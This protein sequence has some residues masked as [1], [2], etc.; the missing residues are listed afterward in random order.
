MLKSK[1]RTF[2]MAQMIIDLVRL[3]P[4]LSHQTSKCFIIFSPFFFQVLYH[5]VSHSSTLKNKRRKSLSF[6]QKNLK[7]FLSSLY[8]MLHACKICILPC[9]S[10]QKIK[11]SLRLLFPFSLLIISQHRNR[12]YYG[13][14]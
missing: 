6:K 10:V 8:I 2:K 14:S 11:R 9:Y 5:I 4:R 1:G 13:K 12:C 7:A 3:L